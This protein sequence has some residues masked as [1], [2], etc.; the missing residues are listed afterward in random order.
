MSDK[1]YFIRIFCYSSQICLRRVDYFV[2]KPIFLSM[3]LRYAV[4]FV[5]SMLFALVST[6]CVTTNIHKFRMTVSESPEVHGANIKQ[7]A[8]SGSWRFSGNVNYNFEKNVNI[9]ENTSESKDLDEFL[10]DLAVLKRTKFQSAKYKMGGVDFSG[11]VDY[12][13]KARGF[14]IGGGLGYKDGMISHLTIGANFSHFEFGSFIGVY[15]LHSDIEYWGET[16]EGSDGVSV[17]FKDHNDQTNTS[18]FAG[19]YA[20]L[21]FDKLFFNLSVSSYKPNPK[22]KEI[23]LRVPGIA[24]VYLTTGYRLNRWF[25]FSVGGIATYIDAPNG[26]NGGVTSGISLYL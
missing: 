5:V 14:V 25:E 26:F 22:M 18:I 21:Y 15:C 20:G 10:N 11:K 24:T 1:R 16:S 6:G 7:E 9:T 19:M 4:S 23:D 13:Y 2:Q 12:L 8:H 17:T 3:K